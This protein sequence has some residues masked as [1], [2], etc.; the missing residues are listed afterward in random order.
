MSDP[1]AGDRVRLEVEVKPV[2]VP[3]TATGTVRGTLVSRGD[4]AYVRVAGL[5][6]GA[7]YHWRARA[8]DET[9]RAGSWAS[10]G[11]NAESDADFAIP[12]R[13]PPDPPT[14]LA[15]LKLD[16]VTPIAV[17]DVT[18]ERAVVLRA[19]VSDA[20]PADVLRLEVEVRPVG[21]AFAGTPTAASTEAANGGTA[22]ATAAGLSEGTAY[23]WQARTVDPAG[24]QSSWVAFGGNVESAADFAVEVTPPPPPPPPQASKL[25]FIAQPANTAAGGI[26]TPAV[27]VAA[28]DSSGNTVSAFTGDVVIALGTNPAGGTLS[29][30][31]TVAAVGGVAT[32]A[33]LSIDLAGSGYTLTASA[34]GLGGATSTPFDVTGGGGGGTRA[35]HLWYEVQPS[36]TAV[37]AIITPPIKVAAHDQNGQIVSDYTGSITIAIDTNPS[38]GTLLG[39]RT[40]AAVG[41]IATFSDLRIDKAGHGYTL[42]ATASGLTS[43]ESGAFNVLGSGGVGCGQPTHLVFLVQPSNTKAGAI[44]TPAVKVAAH[45]ISGNIAGGFTGTITIAIGSNPSGGTLSGTKTVAAVTGVATF[46]DLSIDRAGQTYTLTAAAAGLM[47]ASSGAFIILQ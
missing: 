12:R 38:C 39:T 7:A 18:N 20:D 10:F 15:Q 34:A 1:D 46:S 28:Q 24:S 47:G 19:T 14:S 41:G 44:I 32:F 5:T 31:R 8:V 2:D 22:S 30:T 26:I 40:V 23:H 45:D 11:A 37:G 16:G 3:F 36:E 6:D 21:T 13:R 25:A 27:R 33:D 17:G 35:H 4:P 43:M 42:M 29:G 9:G